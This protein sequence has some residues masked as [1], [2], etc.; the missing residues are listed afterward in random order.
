M[1]TKVVGLALLAT[2]MMLAPVTAAATQDGNSTNETGSTDRPDDAAWTEDCPPD[3]MC[4]YSHSNTSEPHA[5]G[6]EDCIECSGPIADDG[7]AT[8]DPD[9]PVDS[10][11]PVPGNATGWDPATDC[12]ADSQC[13]ANGDGPTYDGNCGGEVCAYDESHGGVP[14]VE[15]DEDAKANDAS[16]IGLVG[17]FVALSLSAV[18]LTVGLGKKE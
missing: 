13:L 8:R 5:Y 11:M 16:A 7:N 6:D 14:P 1:T 4:A 2:L 18:V 15:D 3:M 9:T 17:V 12:P 10:G